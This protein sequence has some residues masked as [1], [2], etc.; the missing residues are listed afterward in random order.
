M[1]IVNTNKPYTYFTMKQNLSLL[2]TLFPFIDV[3]VIGKSV[4]GQDLY[5]VRLGNGSKSVFYSASIHANEWIT[6][7]LL[8]KFIEDY[9]DAFLTNS[10]ID[11]VSIAELFYSTSIYIMPM[12]NPDGVNLVNNIYDESSY[13]FIRAKNISSDFPDIPFPDGW[14][15]NINGV[16]LKIYQPIREVL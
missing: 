12:V 7:L 13:P 14:K 15:A 6:S 8:M 2:K 11:D 9:C 16:D 10:T 1:N 5:L 3:S 4:L